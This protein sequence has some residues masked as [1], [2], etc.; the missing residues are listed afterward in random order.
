MSFTLA[1]FSES[2]DSATLVNVAAL[3]DQH[4]TVSGDDLR[5][6]E[7]ANHLVGV[8][9][10]GPNVTRAML[11]SP[12]LR[13]MLNYEITPIDVGVEPASNPPVVMFARNPIPLV[14]DENINAQAAEDAAGASRATVL[15]WL[16]DGALTPVEGEMYTVRVT[17]ATTLAANVWT[18]AALTFD[19]SLQPGRYAIVG[20]RFIAAGL[21]AF[22]FAFVGGFFR[23]GGVGFDAASDFEPAHQRKGGLGVWGEFP[24]TVPPT[25]DF[26]SNSADT[27]E[28]GELDLVKIG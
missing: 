3:A 22:R 11:V 25:V 27:S 16:S 1:A 13:R 24:H 8:H 21:Q 23:P 6:P 9:A 17:G 2:Q 26:L 20:A 5:V 15:V 19:Q 12:T 14:T 28:T 7:F 10:L 4:L 18:N